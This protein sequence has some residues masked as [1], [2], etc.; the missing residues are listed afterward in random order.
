[1]ELLSEIKNAIRDYYVL[2]DQ[3]DEVITEFDARSGELTA[4]LSPHQLS[5]TVT[6]ILR[7]ITN[8]L[9]FALMYAPEKQ[10]ASGQ[11]QTPIYFQQGARNNHYFEEAKR[12]TGNIG[13]LDIRMFS[14]TR[15][16]LETAM[17]AMAFLAHTDALIF[18][19][20]QHR[21][22]GP[23]MI[24]ILLSYLFD[25]PTHINTF[26]HRGTDEYSQSWTLPYVPGKSM[27][28][29]PVYVLISNTTGSAGEEFAYDLQQLGRGTL[30]GQTTAGAGHT[31]RMVDLNDNYRLLVPHGRPINPV[32]GT[33]W[34]GVGVMPDIETPAAEA[35]QF[36]HLHALEKLTETSSD[37]MPRTYQ[38]EYEAVHARYNPYVVNDLS[39]YTGDYQG[40][41]IIEENGELI[42][43]SPQ[44]G[45]P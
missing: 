2:V 11:A 12:L 5:Q 3:V 9:H 23:E 8:D 26:Y 33:G 16:A 7:E 4:D 30:I 19:I 43:V 31:A 28:H 38:W 40:R 1:M 29:V 45:E 6:T 36:A 41:K 44:C 39:T 13:Y 14:N 21:G 17:A 42:Y 25:E 32:S 37:D 10:G 22:G 24:Q 15:E 34:Q 27:S 20:R 18:D 35:L